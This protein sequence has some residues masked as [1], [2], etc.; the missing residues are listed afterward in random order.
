MYDKAWDTHMMECYSALKK[1]EV[2]IHAT[3]WVNLENMPS[4]R[5]QSQKTADAYL[6]K[7]SRTGK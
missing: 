7:I 4:E 6:Y 2:L 3:I 1:N 5:G